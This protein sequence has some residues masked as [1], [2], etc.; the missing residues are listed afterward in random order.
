MTPPRQRLLVTGRHGFV[1]GVLARMLER[2]PYAGRWDLAEIPLEL[3]LRDAESVL[4]LVGRTRPDVVIHLAAQSAVAD[5][6]R[7]PGSTFDINLT[8]T[9]HLLQALKHHGF[10]GRML[11]V[12]SGEV[13]GLVPADEL[14]ASE[15]RLPK[16]RNPY[17]VSKLAAEAL[18]A[19][20]TMTEALDVVIARPFN[21]I[22]P[23]QSERFAISDF[24]RQIAL[25]MRGDQLPVVRVGN[26]DVSRDFSDV[27]DVV[28]AYFALIEKGRT[29]DVYNV[30]SGRETFVR[31]LLDQLIASSGIAISVEQEQAR[32]RRA[33]QPRMVGD[34][35]KILSDTGWRA[36]SPIEGSLSAALQYWVGILKKA[37]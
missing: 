26:I 6:F 8:G 19:Q 33:E 16:P 3:E 13:Y 32:V 23:G 35:R 31:E 24:A 10:S 29:G 1:G 7:D 15:N 21:H 14:P 9:L 36:H 28:A 11:Y 30:C 25:V 27:H 18:C 12:S 37:D 2:E 34:A 4:D 22:G 20:W 17:A 5:S